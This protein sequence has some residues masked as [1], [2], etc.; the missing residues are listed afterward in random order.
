MK[1]VK[2]MFAAPLFALGFSASAQT[3]TGSATTGAPAAGSQAIFCQRHPDRCA[4]RAQQFE[5][6]CADNPERCAQTK[7][8]MQQDCATHPE[9]CTA[10]KQKVESNS[11]AVSAA[12]Q[13]NPTG[14]QNAQARINSRLVGRQARRQ[15]FIKQKEQQNPGS[16]PPTAP[17]AP[18]PAQQ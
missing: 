1:F 9:A 15:D 5:Q 13:E 14:C 4:A 7:Q 10:V 16:A 11:A 2:L 8:K 12:C 18:A 6:N 3:S 17:V